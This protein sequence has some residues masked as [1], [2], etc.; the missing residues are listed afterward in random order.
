MRLTQPLADKLL[1]QLSDQLPP[2]SLA[3]TNTNGKIL[4]AQAPFVARETLPFTAWSFS[5]EE[6]L[7]TTVP[8]KSDI[9][10]VIAMPLR[11]DEQ[12]L[13]SLIITGEISLLSPWIKLVHQQANLIIEHEI[14]HSDDVQRPANISRINFLKEWLALNTETYDTNFLEN[15]ARFGIDLK[16][17][18]FVVIAKG[19][20]SDY[21]TDNHFDSDTT[22]HVMILTESQW[23]LAVLQNVMFG[24]SDLSHHM[25]TA[26]E[27][28]SIALEVVQ[29]M[30]A[31]VTNMDYQHARYLHHVLTAEKS[32]SL[33]WNPSAVANA[34]E[35]L[36]TFWA[37]FETDGKLQDTADILHVHRNTLA[38]RLDK[39]HDL[40]GLDPRHYTDLVV[41]YLSLLHYQA[42][43]I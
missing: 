33:S 7:L 31:N 11:F 35:L 22:T 17:A 24:I 43:Q 19:H 27:Q 26:Y 21:P 5:N 41:L 9:L 30:P 20:I 2:S 14:I 39:I 29:N 3:I 36:D 32:F 18:H 8:V 16:Q 37:F 40:T 6:L 12:T 42:T 38:Y 1:T 13:G 25:K 23:E 28:A 4:A 34:D 15:A 10:K